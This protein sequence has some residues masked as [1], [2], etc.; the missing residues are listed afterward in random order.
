[1]VGK[2]ICGHLD[3]EVVRFRNQGVSRTYCMRCVFD[4]LDIISVE[5]QRVLE[6]KKVIAEREK[7]VKAR[8]E[9]LAKAKEEKKP[10]KSSKKTK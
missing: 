8:Q 4:K 6:G 7:R 3:N 9:E 10:S 2:L 5:E 1:M